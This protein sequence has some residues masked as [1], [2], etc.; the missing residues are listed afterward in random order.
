[1][2]KISEGQARLLAKGLMKHLKGLKAHDG[3]ALLQDKQSLANLLQ[4]V[5]EDPAVDSDAVD[6]MH[7]QNEVRNAQWEGAQEVLRNWM[8]RV[9]VAAPS[10][11]DGESMRLTIEGG[12]WGCDDKHDFAMFSFT[13]S[14]NEQ[15]GDF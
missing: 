8:N 4:R 13:A 7:A 9:Y 2:K 12:S 1:M 11:N 15:V 5:S 6:A 14:T 10:L 3:I